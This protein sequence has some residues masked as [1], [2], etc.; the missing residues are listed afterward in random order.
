MTESEE[1]QAVR[2]LAQWFWRLDVR[3]G[4]CLVQSCA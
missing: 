3:E 2:A 4:Y 1:R